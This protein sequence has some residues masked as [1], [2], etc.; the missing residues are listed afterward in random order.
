M[1]FATFKLIENNLKGVKMSQNRSK[2]WFLVKNDPT[3]IKTM[4]YSPCIL[5]K[6]DTKC[7]FFASGK[8]IENN[9]KGVKMSQNRSKTWVIVHSF[10][11]KVAKEACL[12]HLLKNR[13]WPKMNQN[14]SF[15][16]KY[17]KNWRND[18]LSSEIIPSFVPCTITRKRSVICLQFT[19]QPAW[20]EVMMQC[21]QRTQ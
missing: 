11:L 2:P 5:N 19:A 17:F 10:C 16:T 3:S 4:G 14:A 18:P 8:I 1:F 6:N 7:M 12:L 15:L 20:L 21:I 9:L 13:K